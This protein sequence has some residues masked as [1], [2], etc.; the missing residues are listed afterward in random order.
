MPRSITALPSLS[1]AQERLAWM[2]KLDVRCRAC[3]EGSAYGTRCYA[4]GSTDL[5]ILAHGSPGWTHCLGGPGAPAER[6]KRDT[7]K[8]SAAARIARQAP[9][10]AALPADEPGMATLGL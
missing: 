6:V 10:K 7:S 9:G 1:P 8:A 5:D 4:C 3:G 2:R